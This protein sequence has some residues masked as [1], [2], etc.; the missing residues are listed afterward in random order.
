MTSD[1]LQ[2]NAYYFDFQPTGVRAIDEIL[3]AVAVAGKRFHYTE[4]WADRDDGPSHADLI[5]EAAN[6][7]AAAKTEDQMA[8]EILRAMRSA[9][10]R[11]SES[12]PACLECAG[13][14]LLH[15]R[16][17]HVYGATIPEL[18]AAMVAAGMIERGTE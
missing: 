2:M 5:Q 18:H 17:G 8:G 3:S 12:E 11:H 10:A 6:K 9:E 1:D 16:R 4:A 15:G 14:Y 7:A 13:S